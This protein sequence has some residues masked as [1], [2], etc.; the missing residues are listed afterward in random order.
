V[1]QRT[2]PAS[3]DFSHRLKLRTLA[4]NAIEASVCAV[5]MQQIA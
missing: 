1:I 2:E 5:H 4:S 3:H